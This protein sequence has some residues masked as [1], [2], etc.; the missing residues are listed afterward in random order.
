M[1]DTVKLIVEIP[2]VPK[3][4]HERWVL[5]HGTPLDSN[6][7]QAE[8][9]AYFDG[10]AYGW[11]EGRK[12]LC[13]KISAEINTPN[14]GTCDYFIVDRIEEIISECREGDSE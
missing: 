4:D 9:Q 12:D 13:D 7:E 5:A 3:N 1:S 8:V 11:E 10:Q 6:S 2:K 14:R